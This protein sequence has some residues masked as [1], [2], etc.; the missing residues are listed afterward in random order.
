MRVQWVSLAV[1]M[2]AACTPAAPPSAMEAPVAETQAPVLVDVFDAAQI[3]RL[4]AP[5]DYTPTGQAE[6]SSEGDAW[7]EF[8]GADGETFRAEARHCASHRPGVRCE[9]ITL[10]A[11]VVVPGATPEGMLDHANRFNQDQ[12]AVFM[13]EDKG[14]LVV[15]DD[16]VLD[17]GI[18]EVNL[19]VNLA[20]FSTVLRQNR[21]FLLRA[22]GV[23]P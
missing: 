7:V 20:T 10:T 21:D 16:I 8:R 18:A 23:I 11:R 4:V 19:E 2:A 14:D 22:A 1:L 6:D 15:S 9:G 17:G 5:M 3:I 12:A 13:F